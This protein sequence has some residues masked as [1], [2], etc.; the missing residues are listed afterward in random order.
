MSSRIIYLIL[1]VIL[2]GS[3][4]ACKKKISRYPFEMEGLWF[5]P[6]SLCGGVVLKIDA[7]GFARMFG[8]EPFWIC[9]VQDIDLSGKA[10]FSG[11][12]FYIGSNWFEFT[13]K[14]KTASGRD[15]VEVPEDISS[16]GGQMVTRPV[17][18]RMTIKTKGAKNFP[19]TYNF[20]KYADY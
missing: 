9:G 17:L 16:S 7:S 10:S 18:A 5:S 19:A 20:F 13:K 12:S 14:P 8:Y 15:S 11:K 3:G 2:A 1:I 4:S 6:G